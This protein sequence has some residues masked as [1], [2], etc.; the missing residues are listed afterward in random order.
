MTK[1]N[2][3]LA[4]ITGGAKRIGSGIARKLAELGY[5]VAITCNHSKDDAASLCGEISKDFGVNCDFYSVDLFD[6]AQVKDFSQEFFSKNKNCNLLVNN[7]SIFERSLFLQDDFDELTRNMNIHLNSP[8][9]LSKAFALN[10]NKEELLNCQIINLIDKNIARFDTGYFYYLLSK[11]A[12]ADATKMLA[13][14]LSPTIRVNGISPGY[15]LDAID[16][17]KDLSEYKERIINKIPLHR[18]GD[19]QNI[20]QTVEF[21]IKNDFVNGQIIA[22]DGGASLNH[23]G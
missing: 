3:N 22:I 15:I 7:A 4:L 17:S 21:L 11:K 12:L 13:L 9:I 8:L 14:Q 23:A 18:K 19:L 16:G 6:L 5:D 2:R 20:I 1:T 10:T